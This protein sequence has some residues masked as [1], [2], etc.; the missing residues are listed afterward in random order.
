MACSPGWPGVA[1]AGLED[2]RQARGPDPTGDRL[3]LVPSEQAPKCGIGTRMSST[4][5]VF[6]VGVTVPVVCAE[7]WLPKKS[8][9]TQVSVLRPSRQPRMSP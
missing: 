1:D 5:P 2:E 9:S 3:E 6:W 8:K 4:L 7:I